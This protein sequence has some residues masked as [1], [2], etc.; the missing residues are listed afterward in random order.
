MIF[1]RNFEHD[2]IVFKAALEVIKP[3]RIKFLRRNSAVLDL[4]VLVA[5]EEYDSAVQVA[6]DTGRPILDFFQWLIGE[7]HLE[8]ILELIFALIGGG[9]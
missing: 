7:G 9:I 3:K 1:N 2:R 8:R 5:R 6:Q 4:A